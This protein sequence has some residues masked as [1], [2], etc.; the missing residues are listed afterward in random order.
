MLFYIISLFLPKKIM[1]V[2]PTLVNVT[3]FNKINQLGENKLN[4]LELCPISSYKQCSNN[5]NSY[6]KIDSITQFDKPKIDNRVN[7][8]NSI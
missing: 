8:W 1:I 4:K 7:M 2:T 3:N 5:Y 6:H